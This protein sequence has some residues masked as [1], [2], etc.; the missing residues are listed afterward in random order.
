[1]TTIT[2]RTS[3]VSPVFLFS[4]SKKEIIDA[5]KNAKREEA[6]Q[7]ESG[8]KQAITMLSEPT[9]DVDVGLSFQRS[10]NALLNKSAET[11]IEILEGLD[12]NKLFSEI[13]AGSF[14]T[15]NRHGKKENY[16]MIPCPN[17]KTSPVTSC[18][19]T[20]KGIEVKTM[21]E[22]TRLAEFIKGRK[23]GD[24]FSFMEKTIQVIAVI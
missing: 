1:M 12:P 14:F 11:M 24:E 7:S 23:K 10:N 22:N 8:V 3:S 21:L 6:D 18:E 15:I 9:R 2:E 5:M 19:I 17:R 4:P 16:L 13:Y 20:I